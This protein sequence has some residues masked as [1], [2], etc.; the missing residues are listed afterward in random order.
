MLEDIRED[1]VT[2]GSGAIGWR[3]TE[4]ISLKAQVDFNSAFYDSQLEEI[5]DFSAQLVLGSSIR[6]A[7]NTVIDISVSEDIVVN[8]SPDIVFLLGVRAQF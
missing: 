1:W 5:G 6:A 7:K 4:R 3:A 8:A 2:Y